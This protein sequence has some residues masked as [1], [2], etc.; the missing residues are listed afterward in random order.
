MRISLIHVRLSSI[1]QAD[2]TATGEY[3]SPLTKELLESIAIKM[4]KSVETNKA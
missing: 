4:H 2:P 1:S 3:A